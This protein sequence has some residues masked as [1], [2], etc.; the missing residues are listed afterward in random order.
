MILV[1]LCFILVNVLAI[2]ARKAS[3]ISGVP[4]M[5]EVTNDGALPED[6]NYLKWAV[7][8]LALCWLAI[9][10]RWL[11]PALW[12]LVFMMIL[13]DDALQ[14]HERLGHEV[15]VNSALP[16]NSLLYGDDLG[17]ILV[18]VA[19]GLVAIVLTTALFKRQGVADRTLSLRYALI[20][21]GLGFFGVGV[22]A[23]HQVMA[24]LLQGASFSSALPR[25]LGL[26]EDGGEMI[27]ASI[28]FA[29]TLAAD[30]VARSD[31]P[32]TI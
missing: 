22:D 2:V 13:A 8:V 17:E 20:I 27:V 28:A 30:P 12:A 23:L 16:S 3:L 21:A 11:A 5:L 15:S 6:F 29:F 10:K 25:L 26:I 32:T 31:E 7:I 1:D 18:F 14:L 4:E 9:R 24:H 19:M